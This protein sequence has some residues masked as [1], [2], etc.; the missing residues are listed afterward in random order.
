MIADFLFETAENPKPTTHDQGI[1]EVTDRVGL[2]YALF[3]SRHNEPKGTILVAQGRNEY[4]EKYYETVVTLCASGFDVATFDWRGQGG[5]SRLLADRRVGHVENFS[6]YQED[7]AAVIRFLEA[8]D[9]KQPI[10]IV[11]HS[12]GALVTLSSAKALSK[13]IA[14]AVISAPFLGMPDASPTRNVARHIASLACTL[15]KG[16]RQ[17]SRDYAEQSFIGNDLT[18]DIKRFQRNQN[19]TRRFPDLSLGPP[20]WRWLRETLNAGYRLKTRKDIENVDIPFL[21]FATKADRVVSYRQACIL[22]SRM[23]SSRFVSMENS[24]HEILQ[25]IDAIQAQFYAVALPFLTTASSKA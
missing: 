16:E 18:S 13:K 23:K 22:S 11:A 12:L 15:G 21:I 2:R 10:L 24:E 17:V 25:E 9:F 14:A 8:S 1:L 4:I 3:K 6:D 5:S 7:L 20:S 19:F